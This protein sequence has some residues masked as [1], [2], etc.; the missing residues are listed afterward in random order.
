M[1]CYDEYLRA[2]F[3]EAAIAAGHPEWDVPYD[4][5]TYNDTPEDTQFFGPNG[6]YLTEQGD[7]FLTWYSNKLIQHADQILEEANKVFLGCKTRLAAKVS[8]NSTYI[9][10]TY[11]YVGK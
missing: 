8:Q 2:E 9:F 1:Q 6:T 5:G 11:I 3:K 10:A 7:F 4:A